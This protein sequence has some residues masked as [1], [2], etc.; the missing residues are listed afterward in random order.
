MSHKQYGQIVC[1]TKPGK[2]SREEVWVKVDKDD[3]RHQYYH[4]ESRK[5]S[6]A[7]SVC[8]DVPEEYT[9]AYWVAKYIAEPYNLLNFDAPQFEKY[10]NDF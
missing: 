2:K 8:P 5:V 9:S 7:A 1:I 10:S 6:T 4:S 3:G